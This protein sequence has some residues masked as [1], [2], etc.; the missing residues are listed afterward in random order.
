[1]PAIR[2]PSQQFLAKQWFSVKWRLPSLCN[3]CVRS[4][5][6]DWPINYPQVFSTPVLLLCGHLRREHWL[7]ICQGYYELCL[8]LVLFF[9]F[10]R[11]TSKTHSHHPF[12]FLFSHTFWRLVWTKKCSYFFQLFSIQYFILDSKTLRFPC[13][14]SFF[15]AQNWLKKSQA[16]GLYPRLRFVG[17]QDWHLENSRKELQLLAN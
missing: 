3:I 4:L 16:G 14:R 12:F 10:L 2:C 15:W 11:E 6:V 13:C 1:M 5:I 8:L 7:A 17:L 9:R